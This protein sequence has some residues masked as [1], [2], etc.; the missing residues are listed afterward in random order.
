[1][2]QALDGAVDPLDDCGVGDEEFLQGLEVAHGVL[3]GG[4]FEIAAPLPSAFVEPE[5]VVAEF[6]DGADF[7]GDGLANG[8]LAGGFRHGGVFPDAITKSC[9]LGRLAP[10]SRRR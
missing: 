6:P 7:D 10:T 3:V 1:M 4:E 9:R 2:V 5:G 8:F